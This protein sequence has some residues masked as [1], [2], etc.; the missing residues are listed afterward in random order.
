M[1]PARPASSLP[2]D[3]RAALGDVLLTLRDAP[4]EQQ[5][6]DLEEIRLTLAY[7]TGQRAR[8]LA[9]EQ[10]WAAVGAVAGTSREAAWQRWH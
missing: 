6:R 7:V 4:L 5:L 1:S 8:E 3:T 9:A 10:S 2:E